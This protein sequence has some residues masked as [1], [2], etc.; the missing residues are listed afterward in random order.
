M[1]SRVL[2]TGA[3][4]FIGSWVAGK[5]AMQ[6][7]SVLA[8][9]LTPNDTLIR[10]VFG[11][12]I[13]QQID[14]QQGSVAD[15]AVVQ[16]A[17][18]SFRPDSI[19]H[20]AALLIPACDRD[21]ALGASVN[22]VGHANIF[23]AASEQGVRHVVYSSSVAAKRRNKT[24]QLMSVYG[25]FKLWAE[26]FAGTWHH[27]TGL[28]S[29][30][31]RP[32]IVF[33][34]GREVGETAFVN[35]A[36]EACLAGRHHVLPCRWQHR[37]EYIGDVADAFVQ[38]A[39]LQEVSSALVSDISAELTTDREFITLLNAGTTGTVEPAPHHAPLRKTP[40]GDDQVLRNLLPA[41][42]PHSLEEGLKAALADFK[43]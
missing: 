1:I 12:R 16:K 6:G 24:D 34:P 30:G 4:G 37:L 5:L 7:R 18:S 11:D 2:I 15:A 33:G 31:L 41:W 22:V 32:A 27:L 28:G 20:L 8:L 43:A 29:I 10:R 23:A 35:V 26:E 19:V 36:I 17:V 42:R 38:C 13:A 25:G 14:W 40:L 39:L 9:D 21:P 3:S